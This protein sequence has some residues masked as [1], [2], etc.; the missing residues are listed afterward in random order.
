MSYLKSF[1][2]SSLCVGSDPSSL[3]MLERHY[4]QFLFIDLTDCIA[5]IENF[6]VGFYTDYVELAELACRIYANISE[7]FSLEDEVSDATDRESYVRALSKYKPV[8]VFRASYLFAQYQE[9]VV[10]Y[11]RR[12]I[13]VLQANRVPYF[14]D[15][16]SVY[17]PDA[18]IFNTWCL[19]LIMKLDDR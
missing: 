1:C 16:G 17:M 3:L 19:R 8:D 15:T 10:R 12:I 5:Q 6:S 9:Q 18:F 2:D 11:I 4:P 14:E 13:D 7:F